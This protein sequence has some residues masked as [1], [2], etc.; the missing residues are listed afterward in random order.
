MRL[1]VKS[2]ARSTPLMGLYT[3]FDGNGGGG[4]RELICQTRIEDM[5]EGFGGG[6]R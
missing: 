3:H 4:T 1:P 5:W 2:T 6:R